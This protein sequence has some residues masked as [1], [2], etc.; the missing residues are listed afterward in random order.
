MRDLLGGV[1]ISGKIKNNDMKRWYL[2]MFLSLLGYLVGA[3]QERGFIPCAEREFKNGAD[4][5][6][7]WHE[8]AFQ[9]DYSP[10]TYTSYGGEIKRVKNAFAFGGKVL[11]TDGN[12]LLTEAA[13]KGLICPQLLVGDSVL[14]KDWT[15]WKAQSVQKRTFQD[16]VY[17]DTISISDLTEIKAI[18]SP[19]RRRF[20]CWM[21]VPRLSNPSYLYIEI[22]NP[23]ATPNLDDA[24]FLAGCT[25]TFLKQ[26]S[27][28]L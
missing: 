15:A 14:R 21:R 2:I 19:Q 7:C 12:P 18:S 26:G 10:E 1:K 23:K 16:L 28:I 27:L 22:T 5:A 6:D 11:I 9:K 3:Q 4:Q 17:P 20:S 13:A 24:S 25:L 8:E